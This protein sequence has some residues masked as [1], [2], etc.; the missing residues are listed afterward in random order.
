MKQFKILIAI[1]LLIC[2]IV[3]TA[4]MLFTPQPIQIILET[5][6]AVATQ[7]SNYFTITTVMIMVLCSFIIGAA[8]T[9]LFYNSENTPIFKKTEEHTSSHINYD[10][11]LPLL[12]DDE[13][14]V[15]HIIKE[16]NGEILQ[17]ELVLKLGH[18]KVR[19]TRIL[20][21]LER[22]QIIQRHRHG[23]TN[24]IKFKH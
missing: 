17:N 8:I 10:L 20:S 22:K 6:Q 24:S 18:S 14:K 12:K 11:I 3:L 19:I 16:N 15:V 7:S 1:V 9:Y 21:S 23:L 5:G 2:S 13:R 4:Y